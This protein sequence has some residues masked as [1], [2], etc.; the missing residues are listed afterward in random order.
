MI[1]F[2]KFQETAILRNPLKDFELEIQPIEYRVDPISGLAS[3]FHTRPTSSPVVFKTDEAVTEK[4]ARETQE[5]CLFCPDKV[6]TVTPKFPAE[7]IPDGRLTRGEATMFP[8]LFAQKGHSAVIA[9]TKKHFLKLNEFQAEILYDALKL[10]DIYLRR[11]YEVDGIKYAEIGENYLYPS[12]SSV[13]HPHIQALASYWP[14]YLIKLYM[15]KAKKHYQ[16]Y[17]GNYWDELVKKEKR[18]KERYLGSLGSTE[19]FVPFAPSR[20]DEVHFVVRDKSN[21]LEFDDS[22][23]R[24]LADGLSRVL[25][26]Y[27][28]TGLSCFNF[29]MYSSPLGQNLDYLWAGGKIVSRS[30]VQTYPTSDVWYGPNILLYGFITMP[31]EEVAKTIRPYFPKQ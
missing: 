11:A 7:L 28:D 4:L 30:S 26:A 24:N 31:P 10:A 22:D 27:H 19:W 14:Y 29:A 3:T 15:E 16:K 18:L 1:R 25:K 20:H 6:R 17:S 2:K 23:W 8:N 13:P 12:G 5:N 9:L 21:F